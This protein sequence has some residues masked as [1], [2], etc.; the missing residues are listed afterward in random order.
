MIAYIRC[1]VCGKKYK[2]K[3][4]SFDPKCHDHPGERVDITIS[5][6]PP[7]WWTP[8]DEMHSNAIH[9]SAGSY[10]AD[11]INKIN[12][13]GRLLILSDGITEIDG[14]EFRGGRT[15]FI[16][17]ALHNPKPAKLIFPEPPP[18][19]QKAKQPFWSKLWRR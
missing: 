18:K 5:K 14:R 1:C 13:E 11:Q 9:L 15:V 17:G 16:D 10:T 8:D 19:Q 3:G 6:L 2:E 4:L 12:P 7:K